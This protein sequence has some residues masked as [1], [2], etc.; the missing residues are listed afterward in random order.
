MTFQETIVP[1]KLRSELCL[2]WVKIL[3]LGQYFSDF[4]MADGMRTFRMFK[5]LCLGST[6]KH[7]TA[8]ILC[9]FLRPWKLSLSL[10]SLDWQNVTKETIWTIKGKI[11]H[12]G[13]KWVI[14]Q[15]EVT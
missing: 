9:Y 6:K 4:K 15:Y 10:I 11:Y 7:R 1:G 2:W 8:T 5:E 12:Q 3:R 13:G 14:F